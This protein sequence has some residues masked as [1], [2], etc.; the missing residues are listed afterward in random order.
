MTVRDATQDD[1]ASIQ[2]FLRAYLD[3]FWDRPYPRPEFSLSTSQPGKWSWRRR[4]VMSSVWQRA[5]F[6]RVADT[7]RSYMCDQANVVD[8]AAELCFGR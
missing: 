8:P 1:L 7:S 4:L 6:T 3:E 5:F 2:A